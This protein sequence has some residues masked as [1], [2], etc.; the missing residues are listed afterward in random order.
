MKKFI[1]LSSHYIRVLNHRPEA[2]VRVRIARAVVEVKRARI[3]AIVVVAAT[4]EPWI[5]GVPK[6]AHLPF[7]TLSLKKFTYP[8][9]FTK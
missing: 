9:N 4:M 2:V 7:T 5:A 8:I 1:S 6:K 3:R